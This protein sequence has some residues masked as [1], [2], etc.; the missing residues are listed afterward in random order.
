MDGVPPSHA[1]GLCYAGG[2]VPE[3]SEVTQSQVAE[4]KAALDS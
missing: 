2:V 1:Y 3:Y 4:Q